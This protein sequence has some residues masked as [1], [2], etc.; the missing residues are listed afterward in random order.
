MQ[1]YIKKTD[2]ETY[3]NTVHAMTNT[4]K[5]TLGDVMRDMKEKFP[6]IAD[7]FQNDDN[8]KW[9]ALFENIIKFSE[10]SSNDLE[11]FNVKVYEE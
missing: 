10:I 1:N 4:L 3:N 2:L 9:N 6:V 8:V 7:K 5:L 11:R